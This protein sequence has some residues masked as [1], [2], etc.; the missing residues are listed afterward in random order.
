MTVARLD[1]A[2]P[3]GDGT[4]VGVL[5]RVVTIL[6][7]VDRGAHTL[8]DV[9]EATG[10]SRS[11]THR[12]LQ[13]MESYDLLGVT[14]SRGYHLGSRFLRLASA[15]MRELPLRD[16]A[17]PALEDL[18]RVTGESA[19]LYVRSMNS[20][21]CID[22]AESSNELRTIVP[23]GAELPLT[24]GSAAKVFLAWAL[25]ADRT[26]LTQALD[27]H[28]RDRLLQQAA[29]AKRRGWSDSS[30]ERESGVASVS[31]PILDPYDGL[32]A[33]VSVS[34]PATRLGRVAAKRYAAAVTEAAREIESALGY[35]A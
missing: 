19:Q 29:A 22:T 20:R 8:T 30:G 15:A 24:K 25:P 31:A 27:A 2:S 12:L 14:G 4:G 26:R 3:G 33:V 7:A 10:F 5:D 9:M 17:H 23:V 35:Q 13:A 32:L 11:T 28:D 16:L 1:R 6:D 21:V 34:G 18:S